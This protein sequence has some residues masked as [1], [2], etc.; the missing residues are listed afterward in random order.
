MFGLHPAFRVDANFGAT[1][2]IAEMLLQSH[3]DEILLLPTLP[4]TGINRKVRGLKTRGN[5][6]V[7]MEWNE[8][9][10]NQVTIHPG[11]DGQLRVQYGEQV[12]E[13]VVKKDKSVFFGK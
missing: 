3:S 6:T 7:D 1:A 13:L 10:L 8:V 4:E 5:Y 12:T 11:T 9:K 2:G